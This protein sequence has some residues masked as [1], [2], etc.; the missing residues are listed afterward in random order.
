MLPPPTRRVIRALRAKNFLRTE[1]E[2]LPST[3]RIQRAHEEHRPSYIPCSSAS[4]SDC[5]IHPLTT[6]FEVEHDTSRRSVRERDRDSITDT[7]L[8]RKRT[9]E[10]ERRNQFADDERETLF[11]NWARES[12]AE[13]DSLGKL[14]RASH[15]A[16]DG[17]STRDSQQ[18]FDDVSDNQDDLSVLRFELMT[19]RP[20]PSCSPR[21]T[22]SDPTDNRLC[23]RPIH[24]PT[25]ETEASSHITFSEHGSF[26][27]FDWHMEDEEALHDRVETEERHNELAAHSQIP[28]NERAETESHDESGI[29]QPS[30]GLGQGTA[31]FTWYETA[32]ENL[33]EEFLPDIAYVEDNPRISL[34]HV[35][36]HTVERRAASITTASDHGSLH[37]PHSD[38]LN[39]FAINRREHGIVNQDV[40][41]LA[42]REPVSPTPGRFPIDSASEDKISRLSSH[43][44]KLSGQEDAVACEHASFKEPPINVQNERSLESSHASVSGGRRTPQNQLIH[45]GRRFLHLLPK[46]FRKEC[47]NKQTTQPSGHTQTDSSIAEGLVRESNKAGR[48]SRAEGHSSP[49]LRPKRS[50][51]FPAFDGACDDDDSPS[52]MSSVDLNKALPPQPLLLNTRGPASRCTGPPSLTFSYKSHTRPSTA[53]TRSS[54]L[55]Q[56]S[57]KNRF[58]RTTHQ[59]VHSEMADSKDLSPLREVDSDRHLVPSKYDPGVSPPVSPKMPDT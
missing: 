8:R 50:E 3:V 13:Q 19:N 42:P 54:N 10:D 16:V 36:S 40:L 37:S 49:D 9:P 22:R 51:P 21:R 12:S 15:V 38:G 11:P 56:A 39:A 41:T 4:H 34:S 27:N 48:L 57:S 35:R 26:E 28:E 43:K 25:F 14:E 18:E 44:R 6:G 53:S 52:V 24:S 46:V 2:A 7:I 55:S 32:I 1:A 29:E 59:L 17:L 58:H 5:G 20:L 47:K 45:R 23:L 30:D 33:G 31:P